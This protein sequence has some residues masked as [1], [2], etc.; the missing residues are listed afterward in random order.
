MISL[1]PLLSS[2]WCVNS[3]VRTRSLTNNLSLRFS[4]AP[5]EPPLEPRSCLPFPSCWN[6]AR[7]FHCLFI[8][9]NLPVGHLR[10]QTKAKKAFGPLMDMA[11]RVNIA[12]VNRLI[13]QPMAEASLSSPMC[14]LTPVSSG[15]FTLVSFPR[16]R[17]PRSLLLV[18]SPRRLCSFLR[19]FASP[20]SPR[21]RHQKNASSPVAE[22]ACRL[23]SPFHLLSLI[24][25]ANFWGRRARYPLCERRQIGRT[26]P[27][28]WRNEAN[29]L[30]E[31][32]D[33]LDA[34]FEW[35]RFEMQTFNLYKIEWW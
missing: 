32:R 9:V 7:Q 26:A 8:R 20:L 24:A 23:V 21:G 1:C 2:C 14:P 27:R 3:C 4:K 11:W 17:H 15:Y 12:R 31:S 25:S 5:L 28:S 29:I 34:E 16:P 18:C 19:R 22:T 10:M 30:A 33:L 35:R 6:R 13:G